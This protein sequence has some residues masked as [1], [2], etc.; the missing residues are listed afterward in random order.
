MARAYQ[1]ANALDPKCA[2][3]SKCVGQKFCF[4]LRPLAFGSFRLYS[5]TGS[6]KFWIP[7]VP[8]KYYPVFESVEA[9][10]FETQ[11][12]LVKWRALD[13]IQ[14]ENVL[15]SE[16]WLMRVA[17]GDPERARN[18]VGNR[19]IKRFRREAL[20]GR[21]FQQVRESSDEKRRP[22]CRSNSPEETD[23]TS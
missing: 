5:Q 22:H 20:S 2:T 12:V 8:G 6:S 23:G 21:T 16:T 15:N 4:K 1:R 10:S 19:K 9:R 14:Q 11:A 17:L 7:N 13:G 3:Q 18:G